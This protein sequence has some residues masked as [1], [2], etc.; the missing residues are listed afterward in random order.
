[1]KTTMD[2]DG[3][4]AQLRAQIEKAE[5]ELVDVRDR[6]G[7]LA[8]DVQLGNAPQAELEKARGAQAALTSRVSELEAALEA[9]D[10]REAEHLAAEA[11]KQRQADT[12]RLAELQRTCDA[13]GAKAIDL[14]TKL[15]VVLAEGRAVAQE[16]EVLGRE[17][18]ANTVVI[19][20][21]PM[22]AQQIVSA[23]IGQHSSFLRPGEQEAAERAF[24]GQQ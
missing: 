18:D 22:R 9:V 6:V 5:T 23:R 16:A 20:Q 21:W 15:G 3:T 2:F 24:T 4:R 11:E 13:A 17:L 12:K 8:L 14:A 1:M 10:G 19:A 7:E